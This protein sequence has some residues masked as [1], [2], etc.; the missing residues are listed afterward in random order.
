MTKPSTGEKTPTPAI[1]F[2]LEGTLMD[3]NYEHI[4]AW[5]E[6]FRTKGLEIP[7]ARI[8]RCV[9]MSGRLMIRILLTELGRT[10]GPREIERL[11][12]IHKRNVEKRLSSVYILPRARKLLRCH[13]GNCDRW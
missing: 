3:S 7:S 9:G 8:H 2:D 13:M 4:V 12:K 10:I 11:E 6:A 5:R 1:L